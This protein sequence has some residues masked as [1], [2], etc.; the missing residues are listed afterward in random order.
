MPYRSTWQYGGLLVCHELQYDPGAQDG[1]YFTGYPA[2]P[3]HRRPAEGHRG[4]RA[5][6][7][8]VDGCVYHEYIYSA[9]QLG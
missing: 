5:L 6:A 2:Q 1:G 7:D 4:T 8:A 3:A 9:L